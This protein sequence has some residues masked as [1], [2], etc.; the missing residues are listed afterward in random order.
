MKTLKIALFVALAV[1]FSGCE[2]EDPKPVSGP[3]L[4]CEAGN[5]G[6]V[7]FRNNTEDPYELR[8]DNVLIGTIPPLSESST[9]QKDPGFYEFKLIQLNG[10]ILWPNEYEGSFVIEQCVRDEISFP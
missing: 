3:D 5:Y 6:W 4:E 10:F 7:R 9:I 1:A 2:K 8:I